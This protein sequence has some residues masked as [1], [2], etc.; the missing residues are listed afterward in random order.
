[1]IKKLL[2]NKILLASVAIVLFAVA[3][4]VHSYKIN[5]HIQNTKLVQ[6]KIEKLKYCDEKLNVSI[7]QG[8]I[9][10]DK[11]YE[12][13]D[14]LMSRVNVVYNELNAMELSDTTRAYLEQYKDMIA[15]KESLGKQVIDAAI[16]MQNTI[17]Q[18]PILQFNLRE[19]L[20]LSDNNQ[21][22]FLFL[23]NSILLTI[24]GNK[25]FTNTTL[26][27][28][29]NDTVFR[30]ERFVFEISLNSFSMMSI[31]YLVWR[32]NTAFIESTNTFWFFRYS[33]YR[34]I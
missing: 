23:S 33:S 32:S 14:D 17:S 8:T 25:D 7:L 9:L 3:A 15:Q 19:N 29:I 18:V 13:I 27:T 10:L 12:T 6:E 22:K 11:G 5:E 26:S 34:K 2:T 31:T 16:K 4:I 21:K 24:L 28:N 20:N 30:F 1:M